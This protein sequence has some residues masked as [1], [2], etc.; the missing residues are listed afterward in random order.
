MGG[1]VPFGDRTDPE[2]TY[3]CRR[4]PDN[5][6]QPGLGTNPPT[7]GFDDPSTIK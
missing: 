3:G 6:G 1:V 4:C 7:D 5:E 2:T